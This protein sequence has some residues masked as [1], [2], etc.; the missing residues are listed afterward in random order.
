MDEDACALIE[1]SKGVETTAAEVEYAQ[2]FL[3]KLAAQR[4]R[5]GRGS[6]RE[7]ERS[8]PDDP[9]ASLSAKRRHWSVRPS[10]LPTRLR[11][12]SGCGGLLFP[13]GQIGL[14]IDHSADRVLTREVLGANELLGVLVRAQNDDAVGR[15]GCAAWIKRF[16]DEDAGHYNVSLVG[17]ARF[18]AV[19][20]VTAE[21]A[22]DWFEVDFGPFVSDLTPRLGEADVSRAELESVVR[23]FITHHPRRVDWQT[24]SEAP[25]EAMVNPPT[26]VNRAEVQVTYG[27]RVGLL[28]ARSHVH[29]EIEGGLLFYR[30][31]GKMDFQFTDWVCPEAMPAPSAPSV[32]G[33]PDAPGGTQDTAERADL[34]S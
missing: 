9:A 24:V 10:D 26:L 21:E 12:L 30:R 27:A 7:H 25:T 4:A 32:S 19:R 28:D 14:R 1:S 29:V 17:V 8:V 20:K 22:I 18:S 6:D 15:V 3:S 11:V 34:G 5:I 31:Q 33:V 2:F 23:W 16:E 13:R